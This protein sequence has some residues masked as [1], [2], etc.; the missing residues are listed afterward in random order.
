MTG[1]YW[2]VCGKMGF[3]KYVAKWAFLVA[4]RERTHLQ[5]MQ[6]TLV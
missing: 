5:E 3:P 6:E 1:K 4:H 2:K